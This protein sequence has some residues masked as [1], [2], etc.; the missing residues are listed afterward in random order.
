[1]TGVVFGVPKTA[2]LIEGLSLGSKDFWGC[3]CWGKMKVDI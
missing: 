3:F 2:F 1:L